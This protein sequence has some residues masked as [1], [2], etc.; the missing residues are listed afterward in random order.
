MKIKF[1]DIKGGIYDQLRFSKIKFADS[2]IK[3]GIYYDRG[4]GGRFA[5]LVCAFY[6]KYI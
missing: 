4:N 3:G 6:I 1:A 5:T 2:I